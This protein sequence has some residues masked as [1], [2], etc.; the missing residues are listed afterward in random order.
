VS[1]T[2]EELAALVSLA[3]VPRQ[4][5]AA[6][7]VVEFFGE[8]VWEDLAT[9]Q[10][11]DRE[12]SPDAVWF[13]SDRGRVFVD[14]LVRL[15]LPT[16]T[17]AWA[18]PAHDLDSVASTH[19]EPAPVV[20]VDPAIPTDPEQVRNLAR[21]LLGAGWGRGEVARKLN[22]TEDEVDAVFFEGTAV[23]RQA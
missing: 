18:M 6:V 5:A 7:E 14:Y 23:P 4:S 9:K 13:V 15:P 21:Q 16:Q 1:L 11:L 2:L 20:A 12:L 10:L 3:Q 19:G 8:R 17:K 22:I